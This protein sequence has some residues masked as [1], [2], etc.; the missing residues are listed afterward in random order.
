M[1]AYN[2]SGLKPANEKRVV[3]A[4]I[5]MLMNAPFFGTLAVRLK[6]MM[7]GD[8]LPTAATDGKHLYFN[9]DFLESLDD[10]E[11]EFLIGHEIMHCVYEHM[12]RRGSRD[13]GLWNAAADFVINLEL[14]DQSI[15]KMPK[16]GLLDEKYRGLTSNEVYDLLYEEQE[17]N[18]DQGYE[19]MDVHMEPGQGD[20]NGG[21]GKDGND[22]KGAPNGPVSISKEEANQ[23]SDDI[24]QAVIEASQQAGA[25]NVP[26]GVKRM[27]KDLLE[28]EMDWTE[29]LQME[30]DSAFKSDFAFI[31]PNRKASSMGGIV[32]PGLDTDTMIK[33]A[34]A[35]DTSGSIS[36]DMLR[37]FLSEVKGIMDQH[38]DF[39]V[40]LWFFDTSTYTVHTF[41]PD[42]MND[43][44]TVEIEGGGGTCF[45]C[46]FEMM[47]D[48]EL[49][50]ER[51]IMFTDGYPFGSWG[52]EAYCDTIFVVHGNG[53]SDAPFG[54]TVRYTREAR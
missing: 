9:E 23:I 22:G 29:L 20:P 37:D 46:N 51:F 24:K 25:G 1:S 30:I 40:K 43:I 26:G 18:G 50:P 32:L 36:H 21:E 5:K 38:Q 28:P 52:D 39:E 8:W 49:V 34:I 53:A 33:V 12:M 19:T 44:L 11:L 13:P 42:N 16:V 45:D 2:T 15:G 27:L 47:K 6:I 35:I 54:Q 14:V 17:K 10:K 7:A 4:R 3:K 31:R 41:T 48:I